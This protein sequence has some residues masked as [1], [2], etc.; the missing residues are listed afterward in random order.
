MFVINYCCG[1]T[2]MGKKKV[3]KKRSA[4]FNKRMVGIAFII[5][6]VGLVIYTGFYLIYKPVGCSTKD[7]FSDAMNNCKRIS[8][9]REDAQ[10]TWVY[11][12]KGN[13][14]GDSCQ[15]NVKLLKM[16]EGTIDSERLEGLEMNCVMPKTE[17][18]FPE[19]DISVCSGV[20]KEELQDLIIQR[21]RID[22]LPYK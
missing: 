12:I 18:Q 20:L 11:Q 15:V 3:L 7:C 16:K 22:Y 6:I 2:Y 8:W 14:K 9:V 1:E 17:T 19:K 5:L 4:S 13:D 10:A 21:I